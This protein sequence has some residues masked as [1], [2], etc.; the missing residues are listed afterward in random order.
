MPSLP[1]TILPPFSISPSLL[2]R[3]DAALLRAKDEEAQAAVQRAADISGE[4]RR[5]R[6]EGAA[7]ARELDAAG[8]T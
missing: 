7:L 5:A 1:A 2:L 8:G 4:L 3:Q 6:E